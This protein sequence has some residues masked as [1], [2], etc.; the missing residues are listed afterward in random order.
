M[1]LPSDLSAMLPRSC[2]TAF[3]TNGDAAQGSPDVARFS[4]LGS[5]SA[6]K[7]ADGVRRDPPS[8]PGEA[9]EHRTVQEASDADN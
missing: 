6:E 8:E 2:N 4:R 1:I 7:I 3:L 9:Y 5:A